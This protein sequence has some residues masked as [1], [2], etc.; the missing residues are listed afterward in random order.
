MESY[1]KVHSVL[2]TFFSLISSNALF[3]LLTEA[4][5]FAFAD[6]DKMTGKRLMFTTLFSVPLHY[7]FHKS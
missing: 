7:S 1:H 3:A 2:M 6:S 4:S 5:L